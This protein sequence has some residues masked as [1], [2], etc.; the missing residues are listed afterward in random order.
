MIG[1]REWHETEEWRGKA[2][3]DLEF[4]KAWIIEAK[5]QDADSIKRQFL[6]LV[7]KW[8]EETENISSLTQIVSHDAYQRIIDL[9]RD[10]ERLVVGFIL[11]ELAENGGYWAT[12]LSVIT[13]QNPIGVEHIGNPSKVKRDW[14]EWGRHH[15]YL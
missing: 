7:A 14:L 11:N 6:G 2:E 5:V 8:R 12:A 10:H 13:G 15:G 4:F 1:Y 3:E 9:G